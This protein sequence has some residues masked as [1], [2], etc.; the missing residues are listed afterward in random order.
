MGRRDRSLIPAFDEMQLDEIKTHPIEV[1]KEE[2]LAKG[3]TESAAGQNLGSA[4]AWRSGTRSC[5][6]SKRKVRDLAR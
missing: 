5:A 3:K 6:S 4:I 1:L 2:L